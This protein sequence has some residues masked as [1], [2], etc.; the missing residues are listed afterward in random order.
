MKGGQSEAKATFNKV[1]LDLYS[2]SS[3]QSCVAPVCRPP[4]PCLEVWSYWRQQGVATQPAEPEHQRELVKTPLN[5]SVW[6]HREQTQQC[7]PRT[8]WAM[9][10]DRQLSPVWDTSP[11]NITP[12]AKQLKS[13]GLQQQRSWRWS[14]SHMEQHPPRGN[15]QATW[16]CDRPIQ[17]TSLC[18]CSWNQ[19]NHPCWLLLKA[20]G[21]KWQTSWRFQEKQQVLN[22][23]R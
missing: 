22:R 5:L 14:H 11:S 6:S 12:E 7:R 20:P 1:L 16:R 23:F 19:H 9:A 13:W 17:N 18:Q 15:H 8:M 2:H 10:E 21:L 3:L 4:R